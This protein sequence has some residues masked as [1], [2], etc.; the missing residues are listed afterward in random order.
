MKAK[1]VL[2]GF[3]LASL[4]S[5]YTGKLTWNFASLGTLSTALTSPKTQK[6]DSIDAAY[7]IDSNSPLLP[8]ETA[9]KAGTV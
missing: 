4:Y 2:L 6:A 8:S 5:A 3:I 9:T 1:F 7:F